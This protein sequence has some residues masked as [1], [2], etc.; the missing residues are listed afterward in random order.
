[1]SSVVSMLEE[2]KKLRG[3]GVTQEVLDG[4]ALTL[5]RLQSLPVQEAIGALDQFAREKLLHQP[6][7]VQLLVEHI[8]TM[9]VPSDF[10]KL[11]LYFGRMALTAALLSATVAASERLRRGAPSH[12]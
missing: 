9:R 8:N 6:S 4:C 12:E 10:P 2:I 11:C 3:L 1:M 5:R 7:L